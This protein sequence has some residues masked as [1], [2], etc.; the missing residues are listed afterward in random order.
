VADRR[1]AARLPRRR[2]ADRAGLAP[3]ARRRLAALQLAATALRLARADPD[4]RAVRK[5]TSQGSITKTGSAYARRL[6]VE[7]AWHYTHHPAIGATLRN[8]QVGQPDH[9][10]A[11][12]WRAQHRLHRLHHRLVERGKPSKLATIAVARELAGFLWAAAVAP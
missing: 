8:R 7:A 3:R 9:V 12:A 2:D 1:A 10:L 5:S 6:L 11:I 4:A